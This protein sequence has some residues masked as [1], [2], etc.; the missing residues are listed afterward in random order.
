MVTEF[1]IIRIQSQRNVVRQLDVSV[2]AQRIGLEGIE[3]GIQ[4]SEALSKFSLF[5]HPI[6]DAT[7]TAAAEQ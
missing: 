1:L 4:L 5:L 6:D 7:T 2:N 3:A